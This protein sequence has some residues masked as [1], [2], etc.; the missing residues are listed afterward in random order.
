[1]DEPGIRSILGALRIQVVGRNGYWIQTHC[2]LAP[3][4]HKKGTDR[5]PSFGVLINETGA[6]YYKCLSCGSKGR[7]ASLV[8][9]LEFLRGEDYKGLA[10]EAERRELTINLLPFEERYGDVA[11]YQPPEPLNEVAYGDLYPSVTGYKAGMSYVTGR[12]I[13]ADTIEL[14]SIRYDPDEQRVVFPVRDREGGL[15]GFTGRTV[16]PSGAKPRNYP[17]SKNYPKVRDYAGLPKEW[18]LLGA[19]LVDPTKPVLVVEGLFGY[20]H[21][22]EIGARAILNPVAMLGAELTQ[23]KANLL[24]EWDLPTYLLPDNDEAGDTCL[25]GPLVG[26]G[27][28][29]R[30]GGAA[31]DKLAGNLR[32]FIPDWPDGKADPDELTM[33]DLRNMLAKTPAC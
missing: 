3:Y 31:I 21:L 5:N 29:D 25:F 1:M 19:E 26:D 18:L 13:G 24:M 10:N 22:V 28:D 9:T 15:H 11:T 23:P 14:L 20:A 2:P 30:E 17:T 8:R 4:R 6:S 33:A 7:L 16:L 27:S 12:G 32:L